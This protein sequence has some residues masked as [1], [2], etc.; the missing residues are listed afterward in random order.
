MFKMPMYLKL[1]YA[2]PT[3][4]IQYFSGTKVWSVMGGLT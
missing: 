3:C 1:V 4:M 2:I